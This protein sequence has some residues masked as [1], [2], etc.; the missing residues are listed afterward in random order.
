MK[1]DLNE[2]VI[3]KCCLDY[4]RMLECWFWVNWCLVRSLVL[5]VLDL[6]GF[7]YVKICLELVES[8]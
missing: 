8:L 6:R 5:K 7:D 4:F 2:L 1:D 3:N